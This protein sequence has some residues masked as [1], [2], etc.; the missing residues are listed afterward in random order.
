M[1]FP[2]ITDKLGVELY[3]SLSSMKSVQLIRT[4]ST[5]NVTMRPPPTNGVGDLSLEC[6]IRL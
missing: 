4:G 5:A 3:G 6:D 1:K 2:F